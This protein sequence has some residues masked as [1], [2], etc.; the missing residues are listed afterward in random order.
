MT[1]EKTKSNERERTEESV[2]LLI[3]LRVKLLSDDIS[4]AR[5]AAL[6]LSWKQEDGLAILREALFGNYSRDTKKAAAYGLRSM[7]GRMRKLAA[8]VLEQGL[9][10]RDRT[11]EAAC[12]KSLALMKGYEPGPEKSK[13]F[14]GKEKQIW[15]IR[16]KET[17]GKGKS[18][19]R[20]SLVRRKNGS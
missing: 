10:H 1:P 16:E 19:K 17:K 18:I 5:Q 20:P 13:S 6:N 11:T 3:K 9:N 15:A 7:N 12:I 2:K 4:T 8:E 14:S